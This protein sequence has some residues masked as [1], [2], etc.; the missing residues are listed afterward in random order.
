M[1]Q[2]E[3]LVG[4]PW[5]VPCSFSNEPS[6]GISKFE[7]WRDSWTV[8]PRSLLNLVGRRVRTLYEG[9]LSPV[10]LVCIASQIERSSLRAD[11]KPGPLM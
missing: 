5:S 4:R 10:Q 6:K 11:S 9:I 7:L 1:H 3:D 2:E 8:N